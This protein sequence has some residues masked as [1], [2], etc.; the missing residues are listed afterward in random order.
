V[1]TR[2]EALWQ[3]GLHHPRAAWV[4]GSK[5]AEMK[6]SLRSL[7]RVP[8]WLVGE[9]QEM[10]VKAL[11]SAPGALSFAEL[12]AAYDQDCTKA[13]AGLLPLALTRTLAFV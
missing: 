3:M 12:C 4:L 8:A 1:H 13:A 6:L 7:P 11:S 2:R 5:P 10:A 9:S